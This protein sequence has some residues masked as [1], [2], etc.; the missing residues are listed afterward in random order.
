[1]PMT[2]TIQAHNKHIQ[3]IEESILVVKRTDICSEELWTGYKPSNLQEELITVQNK[4]LFMDRSAAET[5]PEYKQIIPYLVF[6]HDNK[7]F[8]MQRRATASEQR[9]ASKYSFGIGGHIR[10]EDMNGKSF[11]DWALREFN[12]EVQYSGKLTIKP[13][14]IL[15]DDSTDVGKVH[16]GFVI[17]L[18]GDSDDITIKSELKNGHL[19]SLDECGDYYQNMETWSQLVYELL[20][21]S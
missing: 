5:N 17:L 2:Q 13:L 8:L 10:E 20:K 9:L 12:E 1:M 19:L 16:I 7:Y 21:N 6:T 18:S 14:G 4:R 3:P 15:N 11:F